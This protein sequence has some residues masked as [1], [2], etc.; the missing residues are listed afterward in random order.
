LGN[1]HFSSTSLIEIVIPPAVKDIGIK[2]FSGCT[3]LTRVVF[4]NE[5]EEF[6]SAESMREWWNHGIHDYCLSM[7]CFLVRC[8]IPR[9]FGLV[10][11]RMWQSSIH[12]M[13]RRIPTISPRR[14]TPYFDS[15]D[16]KLSVYESV[17]DF[18]ML[19]ELAIW[20][21]KITDQYEYYNTTFTIVMKMRCRTDSVMMVTIIVPNVLSFLTDGNACDD[22]FS[23]NVEDSDDSHDDDDESSDEEDIDESSDEDDN[24]DDDEQ[25]DYN[26]EDEDEDGD[27]EDNRRQRRRLG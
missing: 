22:A 27:G 7:Y 2:A 8:D 14:V 4:N 20:K 25:D 9:R 24:D 12:G 26:D 15:I 21:A 23:S 16:S 19:L 1:A 17:E 6:V 3:S 10:R 5:I 11:P 18:P 13:L